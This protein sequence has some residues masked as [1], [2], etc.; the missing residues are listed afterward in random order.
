MI[1][2]LTNK[3]GSDLPGRGPS[4]GLFL[5]LE[6]RLLGQ[7]LFVGK[8]YVVEREVVGLGQSRRTESS[9]VLTTVTDAGTGDPAATVLLQEACS[10][11]PT[12]TTRRTG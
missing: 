10:K 2:V 11:S 1:N 5:D 7:P 9:W 4:V 8:D 12:P 3:V 6:V